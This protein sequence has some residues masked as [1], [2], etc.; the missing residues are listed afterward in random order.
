MLWEQQPGGWFPQ[1]CFSSM[2]SDIPQQDWLE[3]GSLTP[4]KSKTLLVLQLDHKPGATTEDSNQWESKRHKPPKENILKIHNNYKLWPNIGE[5]RKKYMHSNRL[6]FINTLHHNMKIS[7][8]SMMNYFWLGKK[9]TEFFLVN[10]M[11]L[12]SNTFW[13]RHI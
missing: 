4:N 8:R 7:L 12:A 1:K 13:S 3:E 6:K 11:Y 9:R 2:G 10:K 5:E